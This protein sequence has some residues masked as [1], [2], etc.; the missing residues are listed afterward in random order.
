MGYAFTARW[1]SMVKQYLAINIP[2]PYSMRR[3]QANS[4]KQRLMS[5]YIVFFQCPKLPEIY[6]AMRDMVLLDSTD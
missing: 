1:P 6:F 2:H 5:W 3:E 4:W